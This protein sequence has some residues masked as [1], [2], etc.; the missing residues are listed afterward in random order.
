M[1]LTEMLQVGIMKI[2]VQGFKEEPLML[3]D[4]VGA[5]KTLQLVREIRRGFLDSQ[6]SF[7]FLVFY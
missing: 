3:M 7:S 4:Q 1:V 6:S 5:R 2:V